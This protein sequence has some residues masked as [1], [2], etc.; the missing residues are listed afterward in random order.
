RAFLAVALSV[1]V[2]G[3]SL[4]AFVEQGSSGDG[5]DAVGSPAASGDGTLRIIVIDDSRRPLEGATVGLTDP[6][7]TLSSDA[8]GAVVFEGLAARTYRVA[9]IAVGFGPEVRSV[10]VRGGS[11]TGVVFELHSLASSS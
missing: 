9:A 2:V 8:G 7:M 10:D 1:G 6:F 11:E 5:S 3:G 4:F